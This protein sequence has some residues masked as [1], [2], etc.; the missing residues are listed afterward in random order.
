MFVR[1]TNVFPRQAITKIRFLL[2]PTYT[3]YTPFHVWFNLN[4]FLTQWKRTIFKT[5]YSWNSKTSVWNP[6][7]ML[8]F[9]T[10]QAIAKNPFFLQSNF[11]GDTPYRVWFD[12]ETCLTRWEFFSYT[13][14]SKS[15]FS[16]TLYLHRRKPYQIWMDLDNSFNRWKRP[17]FKNL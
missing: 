11:T 2:H 3:V 17:I 10:R 7:E 1:K 6:Y 4:N 16:A 5:P 15:S 14:Y 9:F 13:G 12:L 8:T